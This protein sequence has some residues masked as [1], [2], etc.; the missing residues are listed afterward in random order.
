MFWTKWVRGINKIGIFITIAA[1][2]VCGAL[3]CT[4]DDT[5]IFGVA[6][7]VL[8]TLIS[9]NTIAI[10]MMISEISINIYELKN[11]GTIVGQVSYSAG[12]GADSSNKP[13]SKKKAP[14]EDSVKENSKYW[15]CSCGAT[16]LST[17]NVCMSCFKSR[18]NHELF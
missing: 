6:I 16:N 13:S 2:I 11:G 10:V 18:T 17:N 4:D 7:M 5:V 8:G 9:I 14:E 1:S 12:S 15:I 3:L